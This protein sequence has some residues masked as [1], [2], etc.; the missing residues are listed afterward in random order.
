MTSSRDAR[1]AVCGTL[2]NP[3]IQDRGVVVLIRSITVRTVRTHYLHTKCTSAVHSEVKALVVQTEVDAK[4]HIRV[5]VTDLM[6]VAI[7]TFSVGN[8]TVTIPVI[9]DAVTRLC[10]VKN[11]LASITCSVNLGLVLP[12]TAV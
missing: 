3:T 5:G 2:T 8:H 1:L 10:V 4:H 6:T 9:P 7:I 11:S 12:D